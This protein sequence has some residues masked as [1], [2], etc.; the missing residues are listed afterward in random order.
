MK[1]AKIVCTKVPVDL[2]EP[3]RGV[4]V[5]D[6][7]SCGLA[8][9]GTLWCWS[10]NEGDLSNLGRRSRGPPHIMYPPTRISFSEPVVDVTLAKSGGCAV[11][12]DGALH[13]WNHEFGF[14]G[15][16]LGH[17]GPV[18]LPTPIP[19]REVAVCV[20][21]PCGVLRDGSLFTAD[22]RDDERVTFI[23]IP[24]T[25]G[26]DSA[27]YSLGLSTHGPWMA[28][29][30]RAGKIECV[31]ALPHELDISVS[32]KGFDR[33]TGI[34]A[35]VSDLGFEPSCAISVDGDVQCLVGLGTGRVPGIRNVRSLDVAGHLVCAQQSD[36]E[37]RCFDGKDLEH[38]EDAYDPFAPAAPN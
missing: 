23:P 19:V 35:H 5:T 28:C 11:T 21:G 18:R 32:D 33:F 16:V 27:T 30:V 1:Q 22:M 37:V 24:G 31:S 36:E 3:M 29:G 8:V 6:R 38:F 10:S 34:T 20:F 12:A 7:S 14:A 25:R 9:S 15:P 2:P 26:F 17:P 4:V 13:C